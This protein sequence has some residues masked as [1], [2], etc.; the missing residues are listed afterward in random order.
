M[1]ESEQKK[2][3]KGFQSERSEKFTNLSDIELKRLYTPKD[4]EELNYSLDL[5]TP[6]NYPFTR[7]A[8][9]TMYRSHLWT[10]RQFA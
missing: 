9:P 2:D 1:T 10:M 5:G 7:G 3:K 6:G 8:Y 4:I